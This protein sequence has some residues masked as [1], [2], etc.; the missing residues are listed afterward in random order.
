MSLRSKPLWFEGQLVRPQHLQQQQRWLEALLEDRMRGAGPYAWGVWSLAL[1]TSLLAL[2]QFGIE[3]ASLIMPDGL[4]LDIPGR[5]GVPPPLA[6]PPG[7]VNALVKLAVP[8][9]A[10][11]R[12]ELGTPTAR[13]R[14]A[15]Q[16]VSNSTGAGQPAS[17]TI[18]QP[19]LR[20]VLEGA[21]E[22][23]LVVFPIARIARVTP[24]GEVV[25]DGGFVPP[26]LRLGA[27]PRLLA[28]AREI[29][30]MLAGRADTLAAR[31]D[32]ARAGAGLAGMI[33]FILL[34]LMNTSQPLFAA[35]GRTPELP[36]HELY[37]EALRL[38]GALATFS[39]GNR[40][41]RP[42]PDWNHGDP[43]ACLTAMIAIIREALAMLSVESAVALPLQSRG[44]GIWVSPV[45]DRSLFSGAIFV[46]AVSATVDP[47]RIRT[48]LPAQ[49]KLGPAEAIRDLVGLQ[50][51]GIPL[52]PMPVAPR[53]IPYRAGTVYFELDRTADLWR[54]MESSPA[55]VLHIG[56][57]IPGLALEFWAI[58]Q[59]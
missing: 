11:D 48:L 26:S 24:S 57:E 19:N 23:E 13:F 39:R 14:Q 55:F 29:E 52:R 35:F 44:Q 46:L 5:D 8:V 31:V 18:G 40:R 54:Q 56:A 4:P 10:H 22:A 32:P 15:E 53:D 36:P 49:A 33:D 21:D 20:L 59:S 9:R 27:H 41:P 42:M 58:R 1:D 16:A 25:L 34:Q 3:A 50:L 6:V 12:A 47:E 28:F 51:P 45:T 30:G 7:T 38:A 2:G 43:G 37:R 17:V